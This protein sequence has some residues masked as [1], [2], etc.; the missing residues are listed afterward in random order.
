MMLAAILERG[1]AYCSFVRKCL[2]WSKRLY[3]EAG[4]GAFRTACASLLQIA[5]C[6]GQCKSKLGYTPA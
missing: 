4:K 3:G 2:F 5:G 1:T 6:Q